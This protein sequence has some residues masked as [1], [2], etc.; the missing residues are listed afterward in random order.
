MHSTFAQKASSYAVL[1]ATV[2]TCYNVLEISISVFLYILLADWRYDADA[3]SP[4]E[5][6]KVN[7]I[8]CILWFCYESCLLIKYILVHR[9]ECV[10]KNEL[11]STPD[12]T[13]RFHRKLKFGRQ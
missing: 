8:F 3:C 13:I 7:W 9:L 1:S 11:P 10:T 12:K 5:R 2:A 6:C 4:T